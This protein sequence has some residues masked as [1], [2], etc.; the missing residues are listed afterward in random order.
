MP[1]DTAVI[2]SDDDEVEVVAVAILGFE[3][4][5]RRVLDYVLLAVLL[6]GIV[7]C[8]SWHFVQV[9]VAE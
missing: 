1:D 5:T 8:Q 6:D 4:S 7:D 9:V 3:I 2:L